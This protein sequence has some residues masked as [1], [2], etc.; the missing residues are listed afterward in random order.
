[1]NAQIPLEKFISFV[2]YVRK[3]GVKLI[4]FVMMVIVLKIKGMVQGV[5]NVEIKFYKKTYIK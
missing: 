4:I 1:M 5:S 3:N 2:I